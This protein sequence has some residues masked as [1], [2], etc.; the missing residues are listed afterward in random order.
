MNEDTFEKSVESFGR[1]VRSAARILWRGDDPNA[2]FNF[3]DTLNA[4]VFRGYEQAWREGAL[5]CGLLPGDRT[6][7]EQAVLAEYISVAQSR[8]MP[9]GDFIQVHSRANGGKWGDLQSRLNIWINRYAEVKARAQQVSC[10]DSKFRWVVDPRKESCSTCLKLNNRIYR[11]SIWQKYD[12][13]PR[14][15]RPGHLNCHGFNCGCVF[16]MTTDPITPGRPPNV[17]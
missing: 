17:P 5:V 10:K 14:D 12:I 6:P 4:A 2:F 8:I 3:V 1:S 7:E 11:A 13:F 16:Q 15:T 9:L